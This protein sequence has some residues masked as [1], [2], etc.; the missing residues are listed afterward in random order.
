MVLFKGGVEGGGG[1]GGGG[2]CVEELTAEVTDRRGS[3]VD[4]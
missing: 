3:M 2:G 1:G 4:N